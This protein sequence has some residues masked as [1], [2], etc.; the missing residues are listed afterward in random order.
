MDINFSLVSYYPI[1]FNVYA[2]GLQLN[3]YAQG[4]MMKT[5]TVITGDNGFNINFTIYESDK[6]TPINLTDA[7]VILRM[8]DRV[9]NSTLL[10]SGTCT[11]SNSLQ[12]SCYYTVSLT[13]FDS[14]GI[15]Q[16]KLQISYPSGQ[17][18]TARKINV[19]VING[20]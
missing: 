19:N 12:G 5:A 14:I 6:T 17:F 1:T 16:G 20:Y 11:I 2:D 3:D 7:T 4:D 8:V 13:D 10:F 18:I 9:D 15:Y